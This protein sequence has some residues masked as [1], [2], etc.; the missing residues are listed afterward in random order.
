MLKGE[1]NIDSHVSRDD[2]KG[3]NK[4]YPVNRTV[5]VLKKPAD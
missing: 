2:N 1:I 4:L 5:G 3:T